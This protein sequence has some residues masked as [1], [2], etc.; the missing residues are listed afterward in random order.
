MQSSRKFFAVFDRFLLSGLGCGVIGLCV[1]MG[2]FI[3]VWQNPPRP[4]PTVTQ[5]L[6]GLSNV[7]TVTPTAPDSGL[8]TATLFPTITPTVE[9]VVPTSLIPSIPSPVPVS[10][11]TAPPTGK[12]VFTC[13][14]N[15]IDQI[16]LMNADGTERK[17]LTDFGATSFYAS[18]SPDGKTIYF[19]S[20]GHKG[21]GGY[22]IFKSVYE[23]GKWSEPENL[24]FPINTPDDDIFFSIS[25]SGKRGYYTSFT[26]EGYGEKDIYVI[27]F[28]GPEKP[29]VLNGEDNL[30]ASLTAPVKEVVQTGDAI[31]TRDLPMVN[32]SE[33]D[34]G[35]CLTMTLAIKDPESGAYNAAFIK[36]FYDFEDPRR[37][38]ITIHSP[39]TERAIN[40]V[41][42]LAS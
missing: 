29:V 13:F 9:G 33:G 41:A 19:S 17:Q 34:Y 40:A 36:A 5:T 25:A 22:D 28:L 38:R 1:L 16:C 8:S 21:M 23:N 15:Q 3:F 10:G 7:S 26:S 35:P 31:D 14:I 18:L 4:V 6:V 42:E 24:G 32:H 27:T 11:N 30:L 37:L 20:Q 12:I 39:D 2:G